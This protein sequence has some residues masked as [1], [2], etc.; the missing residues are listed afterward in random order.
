MIPSN[1]FNLISVCASIIILS[2][3]IF[4]GSKMS[5][6]ILLALIFPESGF[7]TLIRLSF[8][9]ADTDE[10]S[11]ALK[12]LYPAVYQSDIFGIPCKVFADYLRV[13]YNDIFTVPETVL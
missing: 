13:F 9:S 4:D 2:G 10:Y 1:S 8:I 6:S 12:T 3:S 7:I 5:F 11:N